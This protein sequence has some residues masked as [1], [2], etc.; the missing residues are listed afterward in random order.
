[1]V[2]VNRGAAGLPKTIVNRNIHVNNLCFD[3]NDIN[4]GGEA[5][6]M[7]GVQQFSVTNCL[8]KNT[9]YECAYFVFSRSG[10]FAHNRTYKCGRPV[11]DPLND[12]GGPMADTCTGITITN[13]QF[14]DTGF[15]AILVLDSFH[16]TVSNNTMSREDY[17]YSCGFQAIRTGGCQQVT[18]SNNKIFESGYNGIWLHNSVDCGLY[19]NVIVHCGKLATGGAQI[20][21]IQVDSNANKI[22][23]NHILSR[24]I[25]MLNKGSGIALI[26][27]FVNTDLTVY[28]SGNIADSNICSYNERDGIAV[29]GNSHTITNN[30][31]TSNGTSI[32][33]I[34]GNGYSGLALNGCNYCIISGNT[35]QD[36]TWTGNR[37]FNLDALLNTI[38][39]AW[40]TIT[41]IRLAHPVQTQNYG[42]SEVPAYV[43]ELK[44]TIVKSTFN[45][46][47][48]DPLIPLVTGTT[49]TPHG[50][51]DGSV[52]RFVDY[53]P[54]A[55]FAGFYQVTVTSPTTFTFDMTGQPV[56]PPDG[57]YTGETYVN[58]I[59]PLSDYNII[60][61]NNLTNNQVNPTSM[62]QWPAGA[63][64]AGGR[65]AFSITGPR[66]TPA[67]VCGAN[68]IVA[69]NLGN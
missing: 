3:S 49:A 8:I 10:L 62:V 44:Y 43:F 25:C 4:E 51:V 60:T 50:M 64:V 35:I 66:P 17:T 55:I 53:D 11:E 22:N 46:G 59:I 31:I 24:N 41:P 54:G 16:C 36:I 12:G 42:I 38:N 32:V 56:I 39:P 23:G 33:D 1:M 37:D 40:N 65:R 68:S 15:Y 47:G 69:N 18:I 63:P 5:V 20:H 19:D 30:K 13:N 34:V 58:N 67:L 61:S 28:S 2:V 27:A 7:A 26:D 29:Y 9:F 45:P 6:C 57:T 21:G 48:G 52:R 14:V